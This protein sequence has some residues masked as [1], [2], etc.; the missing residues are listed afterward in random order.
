VVRIILITIS[1]NNATQP[2]AAVKQAQH[3]LLSMYIRKAI[4][5]PLCG[6]RFIDSAHQL[7]ATLKLQ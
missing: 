6:R 7:G 3:K 1:N 2:S 5:M 4:P